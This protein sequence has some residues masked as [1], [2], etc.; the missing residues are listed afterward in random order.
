MPSDLTKLE[1]LTLV[2][3]RGTAFQEGPDLRCWKG[4]RLGRDEPPSREGLHQRSCAQSQVGLPN[5]CR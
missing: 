2:L 5:R 3:L 4:I 1:Q